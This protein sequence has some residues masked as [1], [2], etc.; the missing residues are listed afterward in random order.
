[1]D[2]SRETLQRLHALQEIVTR[3]TARI[4]LIAPST[5]GDMWNRHIR[6]SAQLV[7]MVGVTPRSWADLGAGG[8]FPGLVIATIGA[9]RWPGMSVTLVES[10]QRKATF[11]RLAAR[12]LGLSLA[13]RDERIEDVAPLGSHVISARALAPLPQLLGLAA[14]HLSADG[15]ALFPKGR[16]HA[17]EID[18]A[19]K[20]WRFSLAILPSVTE[21]GGRILRIE[22]IER[23]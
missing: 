12:E 4:N 9:E 1:M 15:V 17:E 19:R 16:S 8:G 21:V 7:D 22:R 13:V 10:D 14:R 6:D 23:V 18:A 11:L 5:L 3:W 2:V 20:E